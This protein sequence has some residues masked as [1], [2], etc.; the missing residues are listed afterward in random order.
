M[1]F[2]ALRINSAPDV[3]VEEII[4]QIKAK[5]LKPGE[6]LPSQRELA[7]MFNVGLGSVREA[8]KILDV[9]GYV[10]VVRGK[11][12]YISKT[13]PRQTNT[14]T[15]LEASLE[16]MSLADLITARNIVECG[17][18]G[19]AATQAQKE[20]ILALERLAKEMDASFG[21]QEIFYDLDFKF[22]LAVAEASNNQAILEMVKL[23]VNK[24]HRH[25]NFM[26]DSLNI[27]LPETIKM[28][29]ESARHVVSLIKSGD[30]KGA[31]A[32][33]HKHIY[34]VCDE[35]N[36]GFST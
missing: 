25:V 36:K 33:M 5:T 16:A 2:N 8:I 19:L 13:M 22:H 10:K 15:Q 12:T 30:A 20:N 4:S 29:V 32:A 23:L 21:N 3:L 27:A 11:G 14:D 28:A 1:K 34:I 17:A 31:E 24:S 26:S 7:K 18:A 6:V 35:L 9:M